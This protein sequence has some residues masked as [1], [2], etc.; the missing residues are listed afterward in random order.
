MSLP[1]LARSVRTGLTLRRSAPPARAL[2]TSPVRRA[3]E[4]PPPSRGPAPDPEVADF[5][6]KVG[7]HAGAREAVLRI[8]AVMDSKGIDF[9]KPPSAMQMIKLGMDKE[10]REAGENLVT[11]LKAAGVDIDPARAAQLFSKMKPGA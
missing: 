8:K 7:K 4:A 9:S 5:L 11:Q 10:V 3:S 2:S 1:R 6:D